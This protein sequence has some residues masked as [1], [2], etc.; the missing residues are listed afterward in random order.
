ML[1]NNNYKLPN[2]QNFPISNSQINNQGE[3]QNKYE[4]LSNKQDIN[5]QSTLIRKNQVSF[6]V[7]PITTTL[8]IL[9]AKFA[10]TIFGGLA[11]TLTANA[12]AFGLFLGA[13]YAIVKIN[14]AVDARRNRKKEELKVKM[15][16]DMAKL[17]EAN[18]HMTKKQIEIL[19]I[20]RLKRVA[21]EPTQNESG[22]EVGL[23]KIM[24]LSDLKYELAKR[25]LLP[26]FDVMDGKDEKKA[27][28]NGI[29]FFGPKGTGKSY[30]AEC[31][32]DHYKR[33]GGYFKKLEFVGNEEKDIEY[34]EK[35]FAEAE[36]KFIESRNKKYTMLMLD[37]IHKKAGKE[38]FKN[39][40]AKLL[41]LTN[42]C[43]DRGIIFI[44]ATNQLD[45]VEPALLRDGRTDLRVPVG[46]IDDYDLIDMI[47]YNLIKSK[48]LKDKID[49]NEVFETIKEKKLQY[50]P[51][52]IENVLNSEIAKVKAFDGYITTKS[53]KEC[54][55][56]FAPVFDEEEQEHFEKNKEYAKQLGGVFE[57]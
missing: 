4:F 8:G 47:N 18:P 30:V 37:E 57:F 54:I 48:V 27:V 56:K 31:I 42:D 40:T 3:N 39:R 26:L 6:G 19:Y 20:G 35:T 41:E 13:P 38:D 45:E 16:K 33:K 44:T 32:G 22:N 52:E 21:I 10:S 34:L 51:K 15:L 43:K 24:G 53:I 25:V 12:A 50:K 28:P 7:E 2:R 49:F 29:C 55:T 9:F 17:E 11:I 5:L 36:E 1:I 46:H 14:D 23:N